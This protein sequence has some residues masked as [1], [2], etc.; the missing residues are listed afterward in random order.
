MCIILCISIYIS[1]RIYIYIYIHI[2]MILCIHTW[3]T[4]K[5]QHM[6][7]PFF[8]SIFL[9]PSNGF[10]SGIQNGRVAVLLQPNLEASKNPLVFIMIKKKHIRYQ[11]SIFFIIHWYILIP[12]D[13]DKHPLVSSSKTWNTVKHI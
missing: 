2:H 10:I 4:R 5:N 1:I 7:R 11:V 12:L 3:Y 13:D 6:I 9:G 8:C